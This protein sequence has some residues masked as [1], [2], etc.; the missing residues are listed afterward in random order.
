MRLSLTHVDDAVGGLIRLLELRRPGPIN[1]ASTDVVSIRDIAAAI[2]EVIG[3]AP[4]FEDIGPPREGDVI[5]DSSQLA[6][7]LGR[8]FITWSSAIR[9]VIEPETPA[10]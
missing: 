6:A 3:V 5:A 8:P 9:G 7:L 2:G 4:R 1:I 10:G